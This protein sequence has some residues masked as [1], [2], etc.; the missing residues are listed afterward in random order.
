MY[1]A[2][3]NRS[4][5][6][7]DFS[8]FIYVQDPQNASMIRF[9]NATFEATRS[10]NLTSLTSI[11]DGSGIEVYI[12]SL[13][14]NGTVGFWVRNIEA[15]PELPIDL[16]QLRIDLE[17]KG[18]A[19]FYVDYDIIFSLMARTRLGFFSVAS[20]RDFNYRS[21]NLF[22]PVRFERTHVTT[23]ILVFF[24]LAFCFL[25]SILL[26]IA[27]SEWRTRIPIATLV[28]ALSS[29]S[30]YTFLGSGYEVLAILSSAKYNMIYPISF[31]FHGY[32]THLSGNLFYFLLVSMLLES[33]LCVRRTFKSFLGL[34]AFPL[35]L[36]LVSQGIGLSLSIESMTWALWARALHEKGSVTRFDVL[37]CLIA[38]FPVSVFVGWVIGYLQ[39]YLSLY[40]RVLAV[41]HIGFGGFSGVLIF[42]LFG[43]WTK[44]HVINQKKSKQQLIEQSS[45]PSTT[46]GTR[47]SNDMAENCEE[48]M[49][50]EKLI[51]E[52]NTREN[53]TLVFS[54]VTA[55][56]SLAILAGA[57]TIG[58]SGLPLWLGY[59]GLVFSALGFSY[60]EITIFCSEIPSYRR[61]PAY[62]R[63]EN[64]SRRDRIG[65][66]ARMTIVRVFLLLPVWSWLVW[67]FPTPWLILILFVGLFVIAPFELSICELAERD[68]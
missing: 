6:T 30:L 23:Y 48:R 31:L 43:I 46:S 33:W 60:R 4:N 22:Q 11:A 57:L 53:S 2:L 15:S 61:L 66:F 27:F 42:W 1:V 68:P 32:D 16:S 58:E 35:F 21:G 67:L 19:S 59:V 12:E 25:L 9:F 50:N 3:T 34:Y 28:V 26:W 65:Q 63:T 51:A 20:V 36:T 40:D 7:R 62:L 56:A 8:L 37:M 17:P 52:I 54:T 45:T 29:V 13:E 44:A 47:K 64:Y 24:A 55:S 49:R 18:S 5:A 38:G 14:V 39:G 10:S 41:I